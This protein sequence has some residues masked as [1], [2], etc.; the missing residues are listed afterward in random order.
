MRVL[1][2]GAGARE[3]ALVWRLAQ[4]PMVTALIAAPGNPGMAARVP[5]FPVAIDDIAGLVDLARTQKVDFV[6]VGPEAPLT[7]GLV[8]ALAAHGIKALG[9]SQKAA[10]L[11]G[12]KAFTKA[13]CAEFNI[14]TA[15][16]ATFDDA[17]AAKA[18]IRAQGAPIVVKADGLAAGKGVVVAAN[19][20]EAIEAVDQLLT[21]ELGGRI[22][23]EECLIG[24]EVSFFALC[25]GKTAIPLGAAQ[26]H[27]RAYDGD[28]GPNTGGMGA[29]S[30]APCFGAADQAQV[31]SARGMPFQG[32]LFAGLMMTKTGPKL[33]EFNVRLGDPE[34]QVLMMRLEDPLPAFWAAA[35]GDLAGHQLKLGDQSALVVV[36]AA[37][38]YPGTPKAG[39]RISLPAQISSADAV[40]F[41]AGT[42]LDGQGN[43]IAKGGRVLSICARGPKLMDARRTAY[44]LAG[45][46]DWPDGFYRH[47]I[48]HRAL[49]PE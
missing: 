49:K 24:E 33:I 22:V 35:N 26:D 2:V 5:T 7:L 32:I 42:G 1:I 48:G 40:I 10:Q 6:I 21:A 38:G 18:Y 28:L 44:H 36:M 34:T 9:P 37:K 39:T 14:P 19:E 13:L 25:D 45:L 15:A 23:I 47:D 3:H 16:Y 30:P 43:L 8:D 4:S 31:M 41:H 12:S 20:G 17:E 46:I 11:E 29:Y 27:K